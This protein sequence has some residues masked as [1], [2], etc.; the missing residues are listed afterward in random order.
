M[1]REAQTWEL[2]SE[3]FLEDV[4]P[5]L[6]EALKQRVGVNSVELS[7]GSGELEGYEELMVYFRE[8]GAPWFSRIEVSP[9]RLYVDKFEPEI[10][11]WNGTAVCVGTEESGK[12]SFINGTGIPTR[13]LNKADWGMVLDKAKSQ[14]AIAI[15]SSSNRQEAGSDSEKAD[16][17][18]FVREYDKIFQ[19]L[20]VG[21]LRYPSALYPGFEYGVVRVSDEQGTWFEMQNFYQR[22]GENGSKRPARRLLIINDPNKEIVERGIVILESPVEFKWYR[23][24]GIYRGTPLSNEEKKWAISAQKKILLASKQA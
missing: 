9:L 1:E 15:S 8:E 17:R 16:N 10:G 19:E 12:H 20:S 3:K 11:E 21:A 7:L 5:L 14:L 24:E 13:D 23:Q 22:E 6:D 2:S 4:R 18:N